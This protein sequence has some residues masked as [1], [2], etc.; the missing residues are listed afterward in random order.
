L[1]YFK[2]LQE[3]CQE[4][5]KNQ[6]IEVKGEEKYEKISQAVKLYMDAVKI[7]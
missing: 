2:I 7:E 6:P 3:K 1:K 4:Y 5:F